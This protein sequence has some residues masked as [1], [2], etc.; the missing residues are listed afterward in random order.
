MKIC[1]NFSSTFQLENQVRM[2]PDYSYILMKENITQAY[3]IESTH[4]PTCKVMGFVIVIVTEPMNVA[5][6]YDLGISH[7]F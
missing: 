6:S 5:R 1:G 3:C 7:S 2:F 4:V